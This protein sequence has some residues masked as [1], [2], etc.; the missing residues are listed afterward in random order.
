M[1]QRNTFH[2]PSSVLSLLIGS[3]A[4]ESNSSISTGI[5]LYRDRE[6]SDLIYVIDNV[7]YNATTL[8]VYRPVDPLQ[9]TIDLYIVTVFTPEA[10]SLLTSHPLFIQIYSFNF[11]ILM[12]D[13]ENLIPWIVYSISDNVG[14]F[15]A[16]S[17]LIPDVPYT[18]SAHSQNILN[19]NVSNQLNISLPLRLL[20]SFSAQI[21]ER[22]ISNDTHRLS[23]VFNQLL[24]EG[25]QFEP[26]LF[27]SYSGRLGEKNLRRASNR[28]REVFYQIYGIPELELVQTQPP[29]TLY[30]L[31]Q[32]SRIL[33]YYIINNQTFNATTL[34]IFEFNPTD[35]L[36]IA[37]MTGF[38]FTSRPLLV[39]TQ[40]GAWIIFATSDN[41]LNRIYQSAEDNIVLNDMLIYDNMIMVPNISTITPYIRYTRI[42]SMELSMFNDTLHRQIHNLVMS[43]SSLSQIQSTISQEQSI[44]PNRRS[45]EESRNVSSGRTYKNNMPEI[46]QSSL[47]LIESHEKLVRSSYEMLL[48]QI[49]NL[50]VSVPDDLII[51]NSRVP[52]IPFQTAIQRIQQN[53]IEHYIIDPLIQPWAGIP[54]A[55][56]APP[57][58]QNKIITLFGK[59]NLSYLVKVRYDSET[60]QI[61]PPI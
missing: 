3:S 54:P 24:G 34:N 1:D 56:G 17:I 48:K 36:R 41:H 38:T 20:P 57:G 22:F 61:Y 6:G 11:I 23:D 35:H 40:N 53:E 44:V 55:S 32:D 47:T 58:T 8:E 2:V 4:Q 51:N 28:S 45:I 60:N 7:P 43:H 46:S 13:G 37:D 59:N 16:S 50:P 25:V 9:S 18:S 49:Y 52:F 14:Y 5:S 12:S 33:P 31:I 19:L 29:L 26:P 27:E 15:S 30:Y 21:L 10:L 42:P 39:R